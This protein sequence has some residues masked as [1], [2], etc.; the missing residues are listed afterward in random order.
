MASTLGALPDT[1]Y[2]GETLAVA[3]II[4]PGFLPAT[5][6]LSYTFAAP[7][8]Q[9]VAGVALGSGLGWSLTQTAAN[10][11]LWPAGGLHFIAYA[12]VSGVVSC[13]DAGFVNVQASPTQ[14]ASWYVTAL[15]AV[16]AVI[17]GR[18]SSSQ[19]NFTLGDMSVGYLPL[20]QLIKYRAWLQAEVKQRGP[21]RVKRRLLSRF[22]GV[23]S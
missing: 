17:E 15:A 14:A 3:S 8:A 16:E 23:T 5:A 9:T 1:L 19:Q 13:V 7:T 12:T 6:S 22:D 4:V 18:A 10:T 21:N 2:A 20:D 11:L